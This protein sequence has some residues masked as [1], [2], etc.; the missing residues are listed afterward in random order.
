MSAEQYADEENPTSWVVGIIGAYLMRRAL[1]IWEPAAGHPALAQALT[2]FGFRVVATNDDFFLRRKLPHDQIDCIVINPP[3]GDD[4]RGKISTDFIR[5]ALRFNVDVLML[6]RVDFDSAKT[7]VDLFRD[8]K[9]FTCKIV[10]L[11]RIKWFDGPSSPSDNHALFYWSAEP[12][13]KHAVID[14]AG[15]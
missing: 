6:L 8:N 7:R 4:R 1:H 13:N 3:Y 2:D 14:Y 15:K 5:H 9:R 12:S 11:D 10:L